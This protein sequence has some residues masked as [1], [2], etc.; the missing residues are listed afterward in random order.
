MKSDNIQ[1]VFKTKEREKRKTDFNHLLAE[2]INRAEKYC[3]C[4][5][6]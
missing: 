2:M 5:K 1:N 6:V 4:K 3:F